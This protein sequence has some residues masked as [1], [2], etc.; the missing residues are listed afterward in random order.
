M[1]LTISPGKENLFLRLIITS[2]LQIEMI[3]MTKRM[4]NKNTIFYRIAEWT[5]KEV[6]LMDKTDLIILIKIMKFKCNFNQSMIRMFKMIRKIKNIKSISNIKYQNN[7]LKCKIM[8]Y[9]NFI[10]TNYF[11]KMFKMTRRLMIIILKIKIKKLTKYIK[12]QKT[13]IILKKTMKIWKYNMN[14]I[15]ECKS[16]KKKRIKE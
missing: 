5:F 8:N 3:S 11:A 9:R 15:K 4:K 10:I 16:K 14:L 7:N 12:I 2:A 13:R 1:L 6:L